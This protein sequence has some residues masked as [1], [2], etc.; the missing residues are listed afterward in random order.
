MLKEEDRFE[1][2]CVVTEGRL[3]ARIRAATRQ[4]SPSMLEQPFASGQRQNDCK[5]SLAECV[6]AVA[7]AVAAS[8]APA[9]PHA[10]H[11]NRQ[12]TDFRLRSTLTNR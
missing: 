5:H 3:R 11:D 12:D 1:G 9:L 2:H 4:T 7:V 10:K 8:V 6:S